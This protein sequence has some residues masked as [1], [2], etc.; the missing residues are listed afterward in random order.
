MASG[1]LAGDLP[2]SSLL[3]PTGATIHW[4]PTVFCDFSTFSCACIFFLITL[5]L[6]WPSFFFLSFLP[7][8]TSAVSS[9]HIV[10]SLTSKLPSTISIYRSIHRSIYLNVYLSKCLSVYL[11][12]YQSIILS[13]YQSIHLYIYIYIYQA[14]NILSIN[15]SIYQSIYLSIPILYIYMYT[16][17]RYIVIYNFIYIYISLSL[18][19]SLS[20]SIAI[21]G[22]QLRLKATSGPA[23]WNHDYKIGATLCTNISQ[24]V[25][26]VCSYLPPRTT[27][28]PMSILGP[29]KKPKNTRA[30]PSTKTSQIPPR[31]WNC[32]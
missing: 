11:S 3:C 8:P 12:I 21:L 28:A 4:K 31:F 22:Y 32:V 20:L 19:L 9:I 2:T 29:N 18:S 7:L 16:Y 6:F 24:Y 15:L 5:S 10:G 26:I 13:I 1:Q 14:I 23:K 25:S 30:A 17:Y 27:I